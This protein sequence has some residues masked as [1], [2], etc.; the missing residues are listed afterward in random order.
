MKIPIKYS[1]AEAQA[2]IAQKMR[3]KNLTFSERRELE[4]QYAQLAERSFAK[5]GVVTKGNKMATKKMVE[6]KET[7]KG[8]MMKKEKVQ[9]KMGK[10]KGVAILIAPMKKMSYGGMTKKGYA[11]GGMAMVEQAGKKVPAFAADGIGKM[12]MGG[13]VKKVTKKK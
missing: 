10:G 5:G 6:G 8:A 3:D 2:L 9:E 11:A 4:D 1:A 12:N 13:M 7:S